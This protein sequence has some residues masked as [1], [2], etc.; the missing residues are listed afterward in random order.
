MKDY[1]VANRG[2]PK[3]CEDPKLVEQYSLHKISEF[4]RNMMEILERI[5]S[6]KEH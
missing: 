5:T 2:Y 6:G 3:L 4:R 1:E